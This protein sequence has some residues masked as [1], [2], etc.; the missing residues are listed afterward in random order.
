VAV[1]GTGVQSVLLL[2]ETF[3]GPTPFAG[4]LATRSLFPNAVLIEGVGGST[5]SASL[6]GIGCTD[7]RIA[8]YLASGT[9]PARGPGDRSDVQC[10]PLPQPDPTA[11]AAAA[12]TGAGVAER[13]AKTVR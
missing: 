11:G 5:H 13:L 2:G 1:D 6:S 8:A 9:L 4:A 3:D 7:D 12:A 10:E